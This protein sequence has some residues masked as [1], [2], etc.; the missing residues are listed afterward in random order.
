MSED[1]EVSVISVLYLKPRA[2]VKLFPGH[3]LIYS[4]GVHPSGRFMVMCTSTDGWW[5]DL[6]N[7]LSVVKLW[8]T[9]QGCAIFIC[10]KFTSSGD[11]CIALS[12]AGLMICSVHD[13]VLTEHRH[14]FEHPR[15]LLNWCDIADRQCVICSDKIV[16]WD[17]D[18]DE[19]QVLR[20]SMGRSP[21]N[22][23][24]QYYLFAIFLNQPLSGYILYHKWIGPEHCD[25]IFIMNMSGV[26]LMMFNTKV[27]F[28]FPKLHIFDRFM[29]TAESDGSL[30][31][32]NIVNG[33]VLYV[34][35]DEQS[36][37]FNAFVVNP[38]TNT[39]RCYNRNGQCYIFAINSGRELSIPH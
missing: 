32:H 19:K 1:G 35:V 26:E 15:H 9:P 18:T 5:V 2:S 22:Q 34:F 24:K 27:D 37:G 39:I 16:L 30:R 8:E 31:L 4:A 13:M 12:S 25:Q 33:N 36:L 29:I 23:L 11:K 20:K 3:S 10:V 7:N 6:I 14:V 17:I 38:A 28:V 21:L